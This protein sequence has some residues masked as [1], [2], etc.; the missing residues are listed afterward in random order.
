M[1]PAYHE[2]VLIPRESLFKLPSCASIKISPDGKRLAYVG[3]NDEGALNLYLCPG[4]TLENAVALTSE[5]KPDIRH[6]HWLHDG[7][8]IILLKDTDGKFQCDLYTVDVVSGEIKNLTSSFERIHTKLFKLSRTKNQGIVGINARTPQFRDL[9]LVD[10][11]SG[12]LELVYQN[13]EFVNFLFDEDLQVLLKVKINPDFSHT[14]L[15]GKDNLF[16]E[17][18][19]EDAYHSAW[20]SYSSEDNMVYFLD[21]RG[22]NTTQLKKISLDGTKPDI[23]IAC[24]PISDIHD[25]IFEGEQ[26]VGYS[27]FF[28]YKNWHMLEPKYAM[29]ME[30]IIQRIG[31]HFEILDKGPGAYVLRSSDP[32]RGIEYYL[33]EKEGDKLTKLF[34]LPG[35]DSLAK[36]SPFLIPTRDGK[37]LTSYVTRAKEDKPLP[38]VI[39]PHGGPFMVRDVYGYSP[40]HQWLASRGYA[41]LSLNFRLSSGL[42]KD[43]VNAGNGQ[44][45]GRAHDDIVDAARWCVQEG[46]AEKGKVAIWGGSYGGYEALAALAFSPKEFACCVA[47]CGPSHLRT[48]LKKIGHYWELQR[49][50]ISDK[51]APFSRS[52]FIKS[53]G[54]DP[55]KEEDAPFLESR[56]PLNFVDQMEQPLLLVHG[57]NDPI[58][59]ICES[60][61]IFAAMQK[62]EHPVIYLKFFQEGHGLLKFSNIMYYMACTEQFFAK[63]LGGKVEPLSEEM[64]RLSTVE[65][66]EGN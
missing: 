10:F 22:S 59:P 18:A 38:L 62:N 7:S 53:M 54:G 34:A 35:I 27:T 28:L 65:V 61:Q 1:M 5:A 8:K 25:I 26:I 15:D 64:Q 37:E 32:E 52:A 30:G 19:P 11:D 4:L 36:M 45:G 46:I 39:I 31:P 55:D 49:A 9:Y 14:F 56:S 43:L 2:K 42:G 6:F 47:A 3:G 29:A 66:H 48:I 23:C 57:V 63:Y 51:M 44:W 50:L 13:D 58:V 33:Y 16:L 20:V 24:D 12:M 21:T 17:V 41:V 60:D 40:H